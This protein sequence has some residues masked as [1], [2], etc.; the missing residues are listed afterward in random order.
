MQVHWTLVRLKFVKTSE[1]AESAR[2]AGEVDHPCFQSWGYV[3][4]QGWPSAGVETDWDDNNHCR[5]ISTITKFNKIIENDDCY[6]GNYHLAGDHGCLHKNYNYH[7]DGL[8][9]PSCHDHNDNY[10]FLGN[11]C[12]GRQYSDIEGRDEQADVRLWICQGCVL[13]TTIVIILWLPSP[14][15]HQNNLG[16]NN[17]WWPM[18]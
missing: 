2:E 17:F 16:S 15:F 4:D 5:Y 1:P 6:H 12:D 3:R 9:S 8:W 14:R 18:I 13:N 7:Y 10:H 11:P